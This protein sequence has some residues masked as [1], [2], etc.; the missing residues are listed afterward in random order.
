MMDGEAVGQGQRAGICGA[1]Y[2]GPDIDC[3]CLQP[4]HPEDVPH[5]CTAPGCG[6]QWADLVLGRRIASA[7]TSPRHS[8]A[9]I[10]DEF[11]GD[12]A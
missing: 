6:R 7:D 1:I 4:P 3:L 5:E 11:G 2:P 12:A 8:L 9:E 10:E